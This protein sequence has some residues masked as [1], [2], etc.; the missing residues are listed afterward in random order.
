MYQPSIK[1]VSAKE[2]QPSTFWR[3][4]SGKY[5]RTKKEAIADNGKN[6][7]NPSDYEISVSFLTKY[8]TY[9]LGALV[10]AIV[11]ALLFY[12][13]PKVAAKLKK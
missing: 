5:Y 6:T 10:A 7:A 1:H 4:K 3:S 13:V 9:I 11:A 8:K 2:G 12:F